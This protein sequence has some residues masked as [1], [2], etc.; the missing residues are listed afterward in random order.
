MTLLN[1]TVEAPG[2]LTYDVHTVHRIYNKVH[3]SL[4]PKTQQQQLAVAF[5]P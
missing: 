1:K 2:T 5:V 3:S 4:Q